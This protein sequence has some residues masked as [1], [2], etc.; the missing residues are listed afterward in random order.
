MFK[1]PFLNYNESL[2]L[3]LQYARKEGRKDQ[4][5]HFNKLI[6][7]LFNILFPRFKVFIKNSNKIFIYY[8]RYLFKFTLYLLK[9]K[10]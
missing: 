9:L 1:T 3:E 7:F 2:K 6:V 4:V 5:L 8:N 10:L